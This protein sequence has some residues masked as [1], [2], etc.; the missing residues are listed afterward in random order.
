MLSIWWCLFV[1]FLLVVWPASDYLS[2]RGGKSMA[3]PEAFFTSWRWM[4]SPDGGAGMRTPYGR[5]CGS[6]ASLGGLTIF[7]LL[8]S[9][10]SERFQGSIQR[11]REGNDPII[12]CHHV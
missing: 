4:V 3:L 8:I 7:A 1:M 12:E 2:V 6:V 9:V 11:I 5:F 10:V